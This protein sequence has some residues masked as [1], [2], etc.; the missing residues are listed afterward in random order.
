V[1]DLLPETLDD[2][3]APSRGR[4][5]WGLIVLALV[6]ILVVTLMV[7]VVGTSGGGKRH[8]VLAEATSTSPSSTAA[9]PHRT[10]GAPKSAS[11]SPTPTAGPTTPVTG[12]PCPSAAPCV[13]NGDGGQVLKAINDF[14][15]AHGV[16]SVPGMVTPDAQTC[17]VQS[18]DGATCA[19]HFFWEPVPAQDGAQV[20]GKIV[21][22]GGG[23]PWLLDPGAISF[24]AGWAYAPGPGGAPGHFECAVLKTG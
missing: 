4:A 1:S 11:H 24:S 21:G 8:P 20:L 2:E 14:R 10:S 7:F 15:V 13:V 9:S 6:A 18:G 23:T 19:P 22:S 3:E 5:A 12:N 16:P 17:A